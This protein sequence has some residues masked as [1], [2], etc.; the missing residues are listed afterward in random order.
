VVKK[1]DG[2]FPKKEAAQRFGAALRGA[3]ITSPKPLKDKPKIRKP[4]KGRELI[5]AVLKDAPHQ[6][7]KVRLS[8]VSVDTNFLKA[9]AERCRSLAK[10]AE[11]FTKRRLFDLAAT[12]TSRIRTAGLSAATRILTTRLNRTDLHSPENPR[13]QRS[14]RVDA[15]SDF[16]L[17]TS[18]RL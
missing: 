12:T 15:T 2:Q 8:L 3:M 4:K 9:H 5:P 16:S 6:P 7:V 13:N 1:D 14:S 11:E 17:Q 10:N 18:L